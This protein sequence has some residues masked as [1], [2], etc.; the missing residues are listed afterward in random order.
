[1]NIVFIYLYCIAACFKVLSNHQIMKTETTLYSIYS[2]ALDI[3][4]LIIFR[5]QVLFTVNFSCF[6]VEW[7]QEFVLALSCSLVNLYIY[8]MLHFPD[9][10]ITSFAVACEM[11]AIECTDQGDQAKTKIKI[12]TAVRTFLRKFD[13]PI[14]TIS[15]DIAISS[16]EHADD[17]ITFAL[18]ADSGACGIRH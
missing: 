2:V 17:E 7:L 8:I 14:A 12:E 5:S 1:M 6:H 9:F 16:I 18:T 13:S 15:S 10:Y 4:I 3:Y 11:L